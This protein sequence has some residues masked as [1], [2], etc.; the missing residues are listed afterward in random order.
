MDFSDLGPGATDDVV[1]KTTAITMG[2]A[3]D[4]HLQPYN[5]SPSPSDN[6]PFPRPSD[7]SEKFLTSADPVLLV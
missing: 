4:R 5:P 1:R 6:R 3:Y 2:F 7:S